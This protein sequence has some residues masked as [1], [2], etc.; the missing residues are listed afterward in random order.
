MAYEVNFT[1]SVNKG[2]IIVEQNS[3]NSETSLVLVGRNLTDYGKIVNEN[4]LH[5]L[6][7]F[8]NDSS[9]NNP[10]EG[11]LWY[12]TTNGISQ[13]KIYDGAQWVSS[14]GLNKSSSRPVAE[15][16]TIGD[17]WIDTSNQQLYL[18]SGSGWILVGPDYSQGSSTGTRFENIVSTT[19]I[20]YPVIVS[21]INNVPIMIVSNNEFKPKLAISGFS[22]IFSGV[23]LNSVT[24]FYGRSEKAENLIVGNI[25]YPGSEF[26][27][28]GGNNIFE[29]L[30]R[31]RSDGGI[32][33]GETE[34]VTMTVTGTNALITNKSNDGYIALKVKNNTTAIRITNEGKVGILTESPQEVLD[35]AGNIRTSGKLSVLDVIDS[36]SIGDGSLIVSGGAGIAKNLNVGGN[37]TVQNDV[38]AH[39]ILPI[40]NTLPNIGSAQNHYNDV[41]AKTYFGETFRGAFIG[42]VSGNSSSAAR[43]NSPSTFSIT[44]DITSSSVSFDG[45]QENLEFITTLSDTYFTEKPNYND[46]ISKT[47]KLLIFKSATGPGDSQPINNFYTTT[48]EKIVSIVPTFAVGMMVPFA[49]TIAPDK[50]MICDG[51]SLS[52]AVYV[53]LFNTIGTTYGNP[54]PTLF[55]I[56]DFRGRFPLG[57]LLGETKTLSTD[58]DRVYDDPNANNI[59]SN[60]GTQRRYITQDKLPD[61][62]HTLSGDEGTQFYA[63]T[64]VLGGTDSD[65]ISLNITGG[66]PGTAIPTTG[67]LDGVTTTL[68]DVP[69]YL[70]QQKVGSKFETVPP[71]L[72]INFIIYTGV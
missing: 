47:E 70:D 54:S 13:L 45:T 38:I 29:R 61:H 44:G 41:H 25:A 33:I 68:R 27:R 32:S 59:G 46:S 26:A 9:P 48:V 42:N 58:E 39:N 3:P 50:W 19:N 30:I 21:Y 62:E 11:Q 8:A 65:A 14:G 64:N 16:S 49:G 1:D 7:N 37:V 55:N 36:T 15:V 53:D 28:L 34:T 63:V 24:K 17:L 6:E 2:S 12:D 31:V 18:Y 71:F 20:E 51:R 52:R 35:V 40:E 22:T 60:G 72:T 5:L 57:S 69:G 23:N 10:V 4:F 67:G 43:L 66:A 56:P